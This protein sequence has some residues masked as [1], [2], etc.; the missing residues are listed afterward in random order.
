[1]VTTHLFS[2]IAPRKN[3]VCDIGIYTQKQVLIFGLLNSVF[4]II[5]RRRRRRRRYTL[6]II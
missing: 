3:S 1:M 2:P 5:R 6:H 4:Y